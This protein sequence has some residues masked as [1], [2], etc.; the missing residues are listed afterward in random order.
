[1]LEIE[2]RSVLE[3]EFETKREYKNP[4]LDVV[5][6][7]EFTSPSGAKY[8]IPG[9]YDDECTWKVRFSPNETGV[10]SYRTITNNRDSS[11]EQ[12]GRFRVVE[13]DKPIR[14]FLKTC[15][16]KYWGLEYE[17][18]EPC[19]IF[20]DT[21]YNLFGAA[22]CGLDVETVLKRRSEQGFNLIR[23]RLQVSPYHPPR[24]YNDWQTRS[25]WPWGGSPQKP[26][27]TRFNLD[28]FRKIISRVA[29]QPT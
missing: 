29:H 7:G 2:R 13:P 14:G 3:L 28:Y 27:F 6:D 26:D 10:W 15:P 23:V 5:L 21:M 16:G 11:L 19:F 20:G 12:T 24:G 22:Y 9:F 25:A 17:S 18:G 8:K 4:F 1:M